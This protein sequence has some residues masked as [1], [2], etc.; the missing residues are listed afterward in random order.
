VNSAVTVKH[1]H[2]INWYE[3][4]GRE[5]KAEDFSLV[6]EKIHSLHRYDSW[7]RDSESKCSPFFCHRFGQT[8]RI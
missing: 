8:N 5:S 1:K 2:E 6:T 4:S 7:C 3:R